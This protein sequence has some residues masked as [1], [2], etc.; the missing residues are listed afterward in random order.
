M[1]DPN[2]IRRLAPEARQGTSLICGTVFPQTGQIRHF[3]PERRG[4]CRTRSR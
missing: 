1:R 4:G 2:Q 3:H